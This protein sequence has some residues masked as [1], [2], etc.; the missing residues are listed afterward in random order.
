MARTKSV[1][2]ILSHSGHKLTPR[3]DRFITEYVKTGN[4]SQAVI[5]AG[6]S[7]KNPYQYSD[8]LKR[9]LYIQ[10]EID[11][12]LKQLQSEKI[13]D[14]QEIL[15]YFSSVMRGEITDQ[16]GLEAPLSERTKAAQELAK[17]QIDMVNKAQ[18][19]ATPELKITLDFSKDEDKPLTTVKDLM[20]D[21]TS[22]DEMVNGLLTDSAKEKTESVVRD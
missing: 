5:E 9:K 22:I 17:R 14:A 11:Y 19:V 7:T 18:Q 20:G 13:A 10:E 3:E 4:A 12:R 21:T 15:E 1:S 16:F 2:T 6:Y 8:N